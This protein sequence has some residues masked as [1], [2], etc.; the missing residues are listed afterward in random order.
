M[1]QVGDE[2]EGQFRSKV[3]Q[4]SWRCKMMASLWFNVTMDND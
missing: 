1:H 2:I 3:M 4:L